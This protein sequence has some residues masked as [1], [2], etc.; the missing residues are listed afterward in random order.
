[1]V[2]TPLVEKLGA[3]I[4]SLQEPTKKMSKS[5]TNPKGTI[6]LLDEP[7][8]AR[9]KIMSAVTDSI[10]IVQYDPQQQP[11]ISNLLTILSSLN[12]ESIEDI[13]IRYEGKGYG[14]FKKE[15][16]QAVFDFLSN[17]Q[18]KYKEITSSGLIEKVIKEGDE[19]ARF[20]AR[21]KV[22][23]VKKKIGLDIF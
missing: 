20:I 19:K 5:E 6:D 15:V 18:A 17:L 11:G 9:K 21:K 1:M 7:A 3:K 2:P 8:V 13:V 23:K 14:D 12:G 10:G 16:G 4:F 22:N